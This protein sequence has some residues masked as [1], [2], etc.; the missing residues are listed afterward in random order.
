MIQ[1]GFFLSFIFFFNFYFRL[2]Y[3]VGKDVCL[4]GFVKDRIFKIFF[5][6]RSLYL[7]SNITFKHFPTFDIKYFTCKLHIFIAQF[8]HTLMHKH[9]ILIELNKYHYN[10]IYLFNIINDFFLIN[11]ILQ[12]SIFS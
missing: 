7:A 9:Y 11:F 1:Q 4:G 8:M 10:N 2:Q 6:L 12:K 5:S 3:F